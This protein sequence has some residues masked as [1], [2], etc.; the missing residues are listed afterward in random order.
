MPM[1][2]YRCGD[3]SAK[4]EQFQ[5]TLTSGEKVACP[6]CESEK[7]TKLFSAFAAVGSSSGSSYES[8]Y[9]DSCA[10]PGGQC[11]GGGSCSVN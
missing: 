8:D 7:V 4:F 9:S 2:E 5:K 6:R 3:C 11:C 10:S 1:Y